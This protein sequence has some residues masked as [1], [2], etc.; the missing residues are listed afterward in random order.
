MSGS[1]R[2]RRR[3]GDRCA[4]RL[5][6]G[7]LRPW[8]RRVEVTGGP[9]VARRCGR[10]QARRGGCAGPCSFRVSPGD[11]RP[12]PGTARSCI[13]PGT[14]AQLLHARVCR[15]DRRRLVPVARGAGGAAGRR[16]RTT[17]RRAWFRALTARGRSCSCWPGRHRPGA[18]P[19]WLDQP[20]PAAMSGPLRRGAAQSAGQARRGVPAA[21][22]RAG[23]S[24]G[25]ERGRGEGAA[26]GGPANRA[27]AA[28]AGT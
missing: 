17:R 15:S 18:R 12:D 26:D 24:G 8:L 13:S 22:R 4:G 11:L 2:S 23:S 14:G 16:L 3:Q 6:G 19:A 9:Q 5:A 27:S 21:V 20:R 7:H 28:A 10:S 1:A 25:T